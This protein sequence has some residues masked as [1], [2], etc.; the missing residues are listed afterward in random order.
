M[1]IYMKSYKLKI[2]TPEKIFFDGETEQI[3]IRTTEGDVGILAN[4]IRYVCNIV[5]GPLKVK[6]SNGEREAALSEGILK[7][8]DKG[9]TVLASTAEWSDEIDLE[10]A[11]KAKQKAE[12]I[13]SDKS[14]IDEFERAEIK[15]KRALARLSVGQRHGQQ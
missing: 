8:S 6:D 7:V 1:V 11:E 3:K 15:L 4:H 10:R 14:R 2:V 9:V 13:L 12:N 5:A